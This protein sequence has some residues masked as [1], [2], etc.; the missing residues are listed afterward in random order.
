MSKR[1]HK[2]L[3]FLSALHRG[4]QLLSTFVLPALHVG[5]PG[6]PGPP[7]PTVVW[8]KGETGDAGPIGNPG[9]KGPPG[10]PGPQGPPVSDYS[11]W[12]TCL[13]KLPDK[14]KKYL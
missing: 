1:S 9:N 6:L 11:W 14:Q 2:T 10:D 5:R 12:N 3:L 4:K 13:T 8:L 7:G